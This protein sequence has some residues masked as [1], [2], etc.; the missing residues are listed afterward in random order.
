MF[1]N[2]YAD[3]YFDIITDIS[4]EYLQDRNIKGLILDIDN[5]LI[6][7]NVPMPEKKIL[8]HLRTLEDAGIKLCVVSNNRYERVKSFS[9]KIGIKFF[10]HDALKPKAKGYDLAS[11]EM[12]LSKNEIAAV[13]DQI[14]TD[15][16]GSKRAGCFTILTKP[17]HKG[18]EGF[19][20]AMKRLF[21]KPFIKK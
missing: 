3:A 20:I 10:V 1:K 16:W 7:H 12:E 9:E 4:P 11:K 6:G 17:L 19:F 13:G 18:G 5:T 21:E 2:F 15:V 8:A 14:F